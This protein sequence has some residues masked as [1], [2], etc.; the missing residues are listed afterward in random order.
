MAGSI[1][2]IHRAI[3]DDEAMPVRAA[4]IGDAPYLCARYGIDSTHRT[5]IDVEHDAIGDAWRRAALCNGP[6]RYQ[7]GI[8]A[9][10]DR[11][12]QGR[13]AAAVDDED[14]R[15]AVGG[16]DPHRGLAQHA[17]ALGYVDDRGDLAAR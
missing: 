5:A 10:V 8:A 7:R 3:G 2:R 14:P 15:A 6:A 4:G 1:R 12:S 13:R 9:A 17:A 11:Q 16:I